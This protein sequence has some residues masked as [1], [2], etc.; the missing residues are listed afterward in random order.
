MD[1]KERQMR[2]I[3]LARRAG[4]VSYG[5]EGVLNDIKKRKAKLIVFSNDISE[6]TK[7][8]ILKNIGTLPVLELD[9]TKEVLGKAV[10]TKPTVTLS[11]N[12]SNFKKGIL[13][14]KQLD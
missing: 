8:D 7:N 6:R 13:E 4:K 14:V 2:L 10:G 11:V 3:G 9:I 1:F 5:A 12:D